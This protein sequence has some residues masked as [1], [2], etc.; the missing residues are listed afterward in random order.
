MNGTR[1]ERR[2]MRAPLTVWGELGGVDRIASLVT[3]AAAVTGSTLSAFAP[4]RS[5]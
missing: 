1:H 3:C 4:R 2:C 5:R